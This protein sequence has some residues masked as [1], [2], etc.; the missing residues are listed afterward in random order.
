MPPS[1]VATPSPPHRRP[2]SPSSTVSLQMC[3]CV[4]GPL[5]KYEPVCEREY[6]VFDDDVHTAASL[7]P[8]PR[9]VHS[10]RYRHCTTNPATV[11]QERG[12]LPRLVLNVGRCR[13]LRRKRTDPPVAM[14]VSSAG[15]SADAAADPRAHYIIELRR[16]HTPHRREAGQR[17]AA[18]PAQ[19]QRPR[20]R[21]RSV[22][23][24]WR[25]HAEC[26]TQRDD[27]SSATDWTAEEHHDGQRRNNGHSG[28]SGVLVVIT[29]AAGL[30]VLFQR[31]NISR[32]CR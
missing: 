16:Q 30:P 12:A 15:T 27:T 26:D 4:T 17:A 8:A 25:S 19:Q 9:A 22:R 2:S 31:A 1:L 29:A 23:R 14:T 20:R 5:P 21:T 11:T 3:C 28:G 7:L 13:S 6:A 32:A 18:Y 24:Q 10:C